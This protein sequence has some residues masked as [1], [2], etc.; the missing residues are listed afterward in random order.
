MTTLEER[1]KELDKRVK[2]LELEVFTK[3]KPLPKTEPTEERHRLKLED[4]GIP[5]E[6][7]SLLRTNI[8]K[9]SYWDL[10]LLL[11]YF[12]PDSLMYS[13][14]MKL[15]TELRKPVSYDWLNTEFHRKKYAGLVRSEP[16]PGS[17]ER[18]YKLNEP[19]RRRVEAFMSKL[20]TEGG[21]QQS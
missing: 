16:L 11:L 17:V 6:I 4:L 21:P 1:L 7:L 20:R 13:D 14:M 12:A 19:G 15:S 3:G 8:R 18:A 10:I 2:R 9:V 5:T